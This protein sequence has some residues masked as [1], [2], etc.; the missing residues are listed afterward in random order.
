VPVDLSSTTLL[1]LRFVCHVFVG[2]P[3]YNLNFVHVFT[4]HSDAVEQRWEGLKN[5]VGWDE[6][7]P[8]QLI[9]LK[10]DV[11]AQLLSKV[12]EDKCG[13]II[14]GKRG[15]TGMKRW[16]LGSVSAGVLRGLTDESIFLID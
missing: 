1:V 6:D 12:K 8:L 7:F 3:G 11:A 5:I 4:G 9:P 10:K 16:L 2:K 15:L 14:M 13:T